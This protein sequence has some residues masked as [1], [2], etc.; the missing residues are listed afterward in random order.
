[1]SQS[2]LVDGVG[3]WCDIGR[4]FDRRAALFLDRDGVIVE[5]THYLARS[6]DVRLIAGAAAAIAA[7]NRAGVPVVL[8]TNQSGIGRGL[9]DWLAFAEVQATLTD[10][11]AREGAHLDGVLACAYHADGQAPFDIA[12]HLWR[13]PFPGMILEAARL[14]DLDLARSWIVGDKTVDLAAGRAAGLAGGVVVTTGHGRDH[15]SDALNL[16]RPGFSTRTAVSLREAVEGLRP[17]FD[18]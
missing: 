18:A 2:F 15:Q 9:Y 13:K 3:C 4:T 6:E 1:L 7:C 5:E 17:L 11:L 14:M 10:R 16:A 8:V 12:D